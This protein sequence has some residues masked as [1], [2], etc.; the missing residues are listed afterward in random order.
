MISQICSFFLCQAINLSIPPRSVL[1]ISTSS[2]S[3]SFCFCNLSP[4]S[5]S[6]YYYTVPRACKIKFTVSFDV[7]KKCLCYFQLIHLI[8][9]IQFLVTSLLFLKNTLK[10]CFHGN[11]NLQIMDHGCRVK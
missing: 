1:F 6:S 9:N 4:S 3:S 7:G 11:L 8:N 5:D 2:D 10:C